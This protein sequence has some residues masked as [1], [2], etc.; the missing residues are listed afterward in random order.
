VGTV[1]TAHGGR[2]PQVREV[3]RLRLALLL[4]PAL[5]RLHD[6]LR[7]KYHPHLLGAM[8]EVLARNELY[9]FGV[10]HDAAAPAHL[11]VTT[12]QVNALAGIHVE[13]LSDEDLARYQKLLLELRELLPAEESKRI[14]A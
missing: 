11:T 13:S 7:D 4:D 2:A 12:M 5:A 10:E 6:I 1:C 8:K 14:S 3:A 9:G